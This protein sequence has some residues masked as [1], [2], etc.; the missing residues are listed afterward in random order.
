[1]LQL[2]G[3][4]RL[5]V[6]VLG[7][8]GLFGIIVGFAFRDIAENFLASVLLS[9]RNPFSTGDLIEVA[10]NTGIVQNLN[11]RSTVLLTLAGNYVQIPNANVYKST[12]TNFSALA[13]PAGDFRG[14]DRLRVLDHTGA[15][16]DRGGAGA[17]SGR[18]RHAGAAGAGRGTRRGDGQSARLLLVRQ[19]GLLADEDQFRAAPPH[20]GRAA[21]AGIELPDP[22]REVVFPNGVPIRRLDAAGGNQPRPSEASGKAAADGEGARARSAR[23]ICAT[24]PPRSASNP[25]DGR[26]RPRRIC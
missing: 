2:A 18:S 7:G 9:V 15:G 1:M 22:A 19:R 3:L 5:A 8:T 10:G 6:T 20:Q 12:I 24:R 16:A 26:R 13:E 21:D 23:A 11:V 4:T 14:R 25:R 17:A